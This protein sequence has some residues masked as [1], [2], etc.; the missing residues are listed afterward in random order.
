MIVEEQTYVAFMRADKIHGEGTKGYLIGKFTPL[1]QAV[2]V[3][4][5]RSVKRFLEKELDNVTVVT[6]EN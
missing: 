1:M 6:M 3:A 5:A 4:A 2:D